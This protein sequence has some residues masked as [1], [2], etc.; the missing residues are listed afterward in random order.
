MTNSSIEYIRVLL[1]KYWECQTSI[2]EEKTLQ[3]FFSGK[4]IPED[5]KYCIPIFAYRTET[6]QQCV[7]DNFETQLYEKLDALKTEDKKYVTIRIFLPALRVAASIALIIGIGFGIYKASMDNKPYFA[8][9]YNDPKA[10]IEDAT[11][12]LDKLAEALK[13]GEEASKEKLQQL[14]NMN[15]DWEALDSIATIEQTQTDLQSE[16][17]SEDKNL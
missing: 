1:D 3:D 6:Q 4:N 17:N 11:F 16:L 15:I 12:A 9:T 10:A 7:S 8:E 14:N 5:L 13:K 2:E